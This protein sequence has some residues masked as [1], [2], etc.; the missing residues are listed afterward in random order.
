M[1]EAIRSSRARERAYSRAAGLPLRFS[2]ARG[3]AVLAALLA[4]IVLGL[5]L[6]CVAGLAHSALGQRRMKAWDFD[7]QITEPQ[8][9][10]RH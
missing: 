3:Q 2:Q 4:P 6:L 9:T 8:W 5:L 10:R 7:W 1:S